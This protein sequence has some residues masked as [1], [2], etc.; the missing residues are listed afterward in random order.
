M[1]AVSNFLKDFFTNILYPGVLLGVFASISYLIYKIVKEAEDLNET[2]RRIAAAAIP[3][4]SLVFVI[5]AVDANDSSNLKKFILSINEFFKFLLGVVIGI[6]IV[7]AGRFLLQSQKEI[8]MSI[9][10]IFLS[11]ILAFLLYM[12]M[13][14]G[15]GSLQF[16]LFGIVLIGIV[17]LVFHGLPGANPPFFSIFSIVLILVL[18]FLVFVTPVVV[19]GWVFQKKM[20]ANSLT[21]SPISITKK[22]KLSEVPQINYREQAYIDL[23]KSAVESNEYSVNVREFM[24]GISELKEMG[25]Y[26][27]IPIPLIMEVLTKTYDNANYSDEYDQNGYRKLA[28]EAI[29]FLV[30]MKATEACKLLSQIQ[31][32]GGYLYEPSKKATKE[33]CGY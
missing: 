30:S 26:H 31:T 19:R 12:L 29:N 13:L 17:L 22:T 20:N 16:F 27:K 11:T 10:A 21:P 24:R 3:I 33:I 7:E 5:I 14:G 6:D 23:L 9:Y 15:L 8:W 1:E 2:I 25:S 32:H 4:I 28:I 18:N